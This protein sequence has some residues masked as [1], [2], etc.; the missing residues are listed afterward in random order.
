MN[1]PMG[2]QTKAMM[3]Q[4]RRSSSE[5]R[6]GKWALLLFPISC[7]CMAF[8]VWS[9]FEGRNTSGVT[10]LLLVFIVMLFPPIILALAKVQFYSI[11]GSA[12]FLFCLT[13]IGLSIFGL[14]KDDRK[15]LAI[16]SGALWGTACWMLLTFIKM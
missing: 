15:V 3:M 11:V 2:P 5:T 10:G 14:V 12:L 9:E 6:W 8:L 1:E 7:V 16:I 4:I 13:G